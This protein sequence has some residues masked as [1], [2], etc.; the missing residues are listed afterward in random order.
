MKIL[1]KTR[2]VEKQFDSNAFPKICASLMGEN[3]VTD[4]KLHEAAAKGFYVS[5]YNYYCT[6]RLIIL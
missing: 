3:S 4:V 6:V 5:Q 1:L 2:E